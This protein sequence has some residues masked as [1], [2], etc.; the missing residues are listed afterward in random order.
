MANENILPQLSVVIPLYNGRPFIEKCIE[1]ILKIRVKKEILIIN[2]GSSDDSYDFCQKKF[3]TAQDIKLFTKEN[4]GI[5]QTRNYG[6]K[7]ATGKYIIFV[8]QDDE[9]VPNVIVKALNLIDKN[10]CC[11]LFWNTKR[12]YENGRIVNNTTSTVEQIVD[13]SAIIE[14]VLP[15]FLYSRRS[16]LGCEIEPVWGAIYRTDFIRQNNISFKAFVS[17]ED[18]HLFLF[19]ILSC[20]KKI[21]ILPETGYVWYIRNNSTSHKRTETAQYARKSYQTRLYRFNKYKQICN[22]QKLIQEYDTYIKQSVIISSINNV[23]TYYT[24]DKKEISDI[25]KMLIDDQFIRAFTGHELMLRNKYS[26]VIFWLIKKR[27]FNAACAISY[28]NSLR[29]MF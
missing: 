6:L 18:D 11:A 20:A 27:M 26:S 7:K 21:Y 19:D 12:C 16:Q 17:Y 15:A 5:A 14:E 28:V 2:D 10:N 9:I 29:Q 23:C 13:R 3:Y 4:Q 8:D 25:K 22:N 1:S 24:W